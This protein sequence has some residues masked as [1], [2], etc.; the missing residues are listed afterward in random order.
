MQ[1]KLEQKF[2]ALLKDPLETEHDE[3][4]DQ[5]EQEK[6]TE[7][8]RGQLYNLLDP[9]DEDVFVALDEE[10][11]QGVHDCGRGE[12][13]IVNWVRQS[14]GPALLP[15]LLLQSDCTV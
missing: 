15:T 14:I 3:I 8:E 2:L 6:D 5:V 12:Q 13:T 10:E 9:A 7:D 4:G 1:A 11:N